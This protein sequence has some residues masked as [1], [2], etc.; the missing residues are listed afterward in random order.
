M[1]FNDHREFVAQRLLGDFPSLEEVGEAW[2]RSH[3][4]V[5]GFQG[6]KG[7]GELESLLRSHFS[8]SRR[9]PKNSIKLAAARR[10]MTLRSAVRVIRSLLDFDSDEFEST[11]AITAILNEKDFDRLAL[12]Q[13]CLVESVYYVN[14]VWVKAARE[15][16]GFNQAQAAEKAL[17]KKYHRSV[18]R[19]LFKYL[20]DLHHDDS[21]TDG[22][23]SRYRITKFLAKAVFDGLHEGF[24]SALGDTELEWSDVF[25]ADVELGKK[26]GHGTEV[27]PVKVGNSI[28]PISDDQVRYFSRQTPTARGEVGGTRPI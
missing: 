8:G 1:P 21:P 7:S 12:N 3:F 2:Q 11:Q 16:Q 26:K 18:H 6:L 19:D 25:K 5:L 14:P 23:K 24:A 20:E 13:R 9:P 17:G 15:T 10:P 4:F 27:L 22:T 28:A